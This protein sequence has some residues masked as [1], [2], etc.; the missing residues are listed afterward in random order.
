MKSFILSSMVVVTVLS[1]CQ[2]PKKKEAAV[3]LPGIY[4]SQSENEFSRVVDTFIIHRTS[5]EGDSYLVTRRSSFQRIRQGTKL[6][7]EYQVEQWTG[8]YEAPVNILRG[9]DKAKELRYEPGE[10]KLY[11]GEMGY[12]KVE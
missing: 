12:E 11:N 1:A 9:A 6:P 8:V 4:V 10:N 2:Q 5:L 7:A 3:F